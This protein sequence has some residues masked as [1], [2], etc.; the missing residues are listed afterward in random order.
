MSRKITKFVSKSDVANGFKI[1]IIV[2]LIKSYQVL[3]HDIFSLKR[4][5][6]ESIEIA[7]VAFQ[8]ETV[9]MVEEI[10]PDNCINEDQSGFQLEMHC[11]RTLDYKGVRNVEIIAQ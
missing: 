8:L 1:Y 7:A 4:A 11:G 2:Y 3:V 5:N 6:R 10:G 9:P